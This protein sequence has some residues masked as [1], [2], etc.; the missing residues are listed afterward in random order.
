MTHPWLWALG[1]LFLFSRSSQPVASGQPS[2]GLGPAITPGGFGPFGSPAPVQNAIVASSV[3]PPTTAPAPSVFAPAPSPIDSLQD[4]AAINSAVGTPPEA[5]FSW[6]PPRISGSAAQLTANAPNT[7]DVIPQRYIP[8][9]TP[10][11][12]FLPAPGGMVATLQTSIPVQPATPMP[13]VEPSVLPVSLPPVGGQIA[14]SAQWS[15]TFSGSGSGTGNQFIWRS[16][17]GSLS[18]LGDASGTRIA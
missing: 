11:S 6:L 14:D 9:G 13:T 10:G 4:D 2:A 8:Q 1:A 5:V 12:A 16:T 17:D 18:F 7:S 15:S 3:L